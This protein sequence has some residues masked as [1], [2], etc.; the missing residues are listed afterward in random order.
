[1]VHEVLT[2][3]MENTD[4]AHGCAEMFWVACKFCEGLG[5]RT[6]KKIVQDLAVHGDQGIEFRREGEDH[7]EI[8]NGQEVLTAR[9]DPF[10][11]L[12]GLALGAMAIPAGVIRYL[13]MTTVVALIF[14]AAQDRSSAY[15][16]GV[17]DPKLLAGQPMGFSIGRAV[18]TEDFRNLKA[19]RCPHPR[20]GLRN[21]L[22]GSIERTDNLGQV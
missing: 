7:M 15:L 1:M 17:H 19:A 14:M 2:P 5:D 20:S 18:L 21:R 12:Q 16:D 4:H 8:R 22:D 13:H 9:L 3:S 11:F 6:E 10:L